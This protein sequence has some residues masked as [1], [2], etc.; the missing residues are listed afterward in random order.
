MELTVIGQGLAGRQVNGDV[1]GD[2]ALP[3]GGAEALD[4]LAQ[5]A[6]TGTRTRSDPAVELLRRARNPRAAR[7]RADQHLRSAGRGRPRLELRGPDL[8]TSPETAHQDQ[9]VAHLLHARIEIDA[10]R[11]EVSLR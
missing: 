7:P 1:G 5:L 11:V 2:G 10:D 3:P 6:H 8:F 9:P 4:T